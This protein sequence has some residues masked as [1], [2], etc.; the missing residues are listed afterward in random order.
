MWQIPGAVL[1]VCLGSIGNGE[2]LTDLSRHV[3]TSFNGRK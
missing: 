3:F 1:H 2:T